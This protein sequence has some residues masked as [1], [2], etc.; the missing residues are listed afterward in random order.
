MSKENISLNLAWL[1]PKEMNLYGDRGNIIAL[2]YRCAKRDIK[3]TIKKIGIADKMDLGQIDLI[4]FGGGQDKQQMAVALDLQTKKKAMVDFY[5]ANKPLLA[6]CGGYQLLGEYFMTNDK[7]KI[8]GLG[9]LKLITIGSN[10]RMIG[11]VTIQSEKLKT[12]IIGFENHS[13]KTCLED[14]GQSLGNVLRGYG[15]NGDDQTEGIIS[16]NFIGTYLHGPLL[17][18]NPKMADW[19]I[20][21]AL[22]VKYGKTIMLEKINDDLENKARK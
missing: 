14:E 3:L 1:Y 15:N 20:Q 8:P 17:P 2:S 7:K 21:K 13:G 18:R 9:I 4:F 10:K 16:N 19:L 6:I 12:K 22:E 11:N 5:N